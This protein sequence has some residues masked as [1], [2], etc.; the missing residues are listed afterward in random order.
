[1]A[2]ESSRGVSG[3]YSAVSAYLNDIR[4]PCSKS[5]L[6]TY[7][8]SHGAPQ[9]VIDALQKMPEQQYIDFA[10]VIDKFS[11]VNR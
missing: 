7:A 11:Q 4:Y 3:L 9:M 2:Q 1:M 5:D 10:Q 8:A 6:I